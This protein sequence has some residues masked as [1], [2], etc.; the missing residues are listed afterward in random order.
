MTHFVDEKPETQAKE[1]IIFFEA[2]SQAATVG[3]PQWPWVQNLQDTGY[4]GGTPVL[5]QVP[6]LRREQLRNAVTSPTPCDPSLF[7][8]PA[9]FPGKNIQRETHLPEVVK[10]PALALGSSAWPAGLT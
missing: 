2:R 6:G 4:R 9:G 3:W 1:V 7:P 5:G 10:N 8:S